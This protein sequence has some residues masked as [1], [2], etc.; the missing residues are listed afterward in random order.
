M[1]KHDRIHLYLDN[2]AAGKKHTQMALQWS[3]KYVDQSHHYR[4]YKDLNQK[5]MQQPGIS[6]RQS[7]HRGRRF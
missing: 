7:L 1:E 5:L 4:Q 3:K 2:D 6:R